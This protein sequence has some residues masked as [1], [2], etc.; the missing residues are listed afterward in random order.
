M[1]SMQKAACYGPRSLVLLVRILHHN[2]CISGWQLS[3]GFSFSLHLQLKNVHNYV[4]VP[5]FWNVHHINWKS[6][7]MLS[8]YGFKLWFKKNDCNWAAPLINNPLLSYL[9]SYWT[10]I[11]SS[12]IPCI[13][14]KPEYH[15]DKWPFTG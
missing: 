15:I 1:L 4:I 9:S 5:R 11:L 8:F 10:E 6:T 2:A 3:V 12:F 13:G 7:L 14:H